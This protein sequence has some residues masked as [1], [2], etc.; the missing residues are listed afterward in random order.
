MKKFIRYVAVQVIAYGLDM[1]GFLFCQKYLG[2]EPIVANVVGKIAS[3]IFAFFVHRTFTFRLAPGE[4]KATQALRYF[5]LLAL[6]VP[7]S[8]AV[9]SGVIRVV[10]PPALAKFISD[11]LCVFLTYWLTKKFVF[12]KPPRTIAQSPVQEGR[13][14]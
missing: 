12:T 5:L 10:S 2:I 13:D 14:A 7:L 9:L 1:G 6:N 11:V 8:S 4:K 3:G